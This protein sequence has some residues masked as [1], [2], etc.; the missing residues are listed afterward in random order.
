MTRFRPMSLITLEIVQREF[1][2]LPRLYFLMCRKDRKKSNK[3]MRRF[4][5]WDK[6]DN[7]KIDKIFD[8]VKIKTQNYKR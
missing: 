4:K 8:Y 5:Q 3:I 6:R 1:M 7:K 2:N